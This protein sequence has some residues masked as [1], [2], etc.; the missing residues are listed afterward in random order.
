MSC[1]LLVMAALWNS[2]GHYIFALW[3]LSFFVFSSPNLSGRRLDIYHTSC[4]PSPNLDCRSEMCCTR[5]AGNAGRKNGHKF[6]I[7]A[8]SHNFVGL[9][10]PNEGTYRQSE[11]KL[12]KQQY[13]LHMSH[14]MVNF[15]PL[16]AEIVSLVWA[17]Q[18]IS[19][20]FAS[21]QRYC[22]AL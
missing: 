20:G 12:I 21:W 4:G 18:L 16:A 6:A 1:C 11:K 10:L 8:P 7:W 3:F 13:L 17:P 15:G 22:T 2:A 9:Y 5:L 14:S 19:T